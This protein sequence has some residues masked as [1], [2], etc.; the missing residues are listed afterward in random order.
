MV[1]WEAAL[2]QPADEYGIEFHV[3]WAE[4]RR[5]DGDIET[6]LGCVCRA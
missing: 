6:R 2:G 1:Y 5:R 3:D 4:F